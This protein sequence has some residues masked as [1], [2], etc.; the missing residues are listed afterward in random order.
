M[1][2]EQILK[3]VNKGLKLYA[4]VVKTAP[5][6]PLKAVDEYEDWFKTDFIMELLKRL[7]IEKGKWKATPDS[8]KVIGIGGKLAVDG[9]NKIL[10]PVLNAWIEREYPKFWQQGLEYN[11]LMA[12]M[13]G[14]PEPEP[15]GDDD[16]AQIN[17]MATGEIATQLDHVDHH[18]RYIERNIS[19]GLS[20]GWTTDRFL[21]AMTVPAGIVGYPYGNTRYSWRTHITRMIEG[22]SRS[23]FAS[24]SESRALA[25][26]E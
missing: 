25:V 19:S 22:R 16:L 14:Y 10:L 24:A 4:D 11:A 26:N 8:H 13:Q 15:F 9:C 2:P 23:V 20:Q 1:K 5:T 17:I 18:R 3:D 12:K 6:Y 21:Q 7:T